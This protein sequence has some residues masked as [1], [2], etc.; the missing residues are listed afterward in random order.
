MLRRIIKIAQNREI[1][2]TAKSTESNVIWR[3]ILFFEN[4]GFQNK[5]FQKPK[6]VARL[7][8]ANIIDSNHRRVQI[9][10]TRV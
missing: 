8:L 6:E 10:N 1:L 3:F 7:A 2:P 9:E 4:G 5:T